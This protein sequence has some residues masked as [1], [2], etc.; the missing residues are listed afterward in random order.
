MIL[1]CDAICILFFNA[2]KS[3]NLIF[4]SF[5]VILMITCFFK[6]PIF[7]IGFCKLKIF[8]TFQSTN[9]ITRQQNLS[10]AFWRISYNFPIELSRICLINSV[11]NQGSKNRQ[12]S[13]DFRPRV[14]GDDFISAQNA[15][16]GLQFANSKLSEH[17]WCFKFAFDLYLDHQSLDNPTFVTCMPQ[18]KSINSFSS[19]LLMFCNI[20][21]IA[22]FKYR[23]SRNS[24][25]QL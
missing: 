22:T 4:E 25:A 13:N 19:L 12:N 3:K 16:K 9:A 8:R 24:F 20:S 15:G 14:V 7:P 10:R 21:S 2:P 1:S 17:V 23:K 6:I 18:F 11:H 5:S